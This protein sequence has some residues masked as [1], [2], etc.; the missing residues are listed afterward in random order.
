MISPDGK[1]MIIERDVSK[2]LG[3]L[4]PDL[5]KDI[6]RLRR[7]LAKSGDI[8]DVEKKIILLFDNDEHHY[9]YNVCYMQTYQEG[10]LPI[11]VEDFEYVPRSLSNDQKNR[12]TRIQS[13][14]TFRI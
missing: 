1:P 3:L 4:G 12:R 11:V 6:R 14:Y 5:A 2:F 10:M 9:E 8:V 7:R 13:R